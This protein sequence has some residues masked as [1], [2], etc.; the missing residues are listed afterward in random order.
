MAN[1]QGFDF[2]YTFN[3]LPQ[4]VSFDA[5]ASDLDRLTATGAISYWIGQH[6]KVSRDH[7]Q[8][9]VQFPE[10]GRCVRL[11]HLLRNLNGPRYSRCNPHGEYRWGTI[12]QAAAYCSKEE[13]RVHGPR[14]AGH[15]QAVS[16]R[17]LRNFTIAFDSDWFSSNNNWND[18]YAN[19]S[20]TDTDQ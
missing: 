20:D 12:E 10:R 1:K 7:F 9:F 16:E 17:L 3:E 2:L 18:L 6:E 11:I 13:S 4:T 15:R 8:I 14:E 19:N 5:F